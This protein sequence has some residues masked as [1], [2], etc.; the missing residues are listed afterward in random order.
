LL[1]LEETLSLMVEASRQTYWLVCP[2]AVSPPRT[3]QGPAAPSQRGHVASLC[4]F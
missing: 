2:Y 4:G 3:P 1:S